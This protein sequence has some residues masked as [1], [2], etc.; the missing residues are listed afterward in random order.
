MQIN[1]TYNCSNSLDLRDRSPGTIKKKHSVSE[2]DLT[3]HR[4]N[5]LFLGSQKFE[6]NN[7]YSYSTVRNI[8]SF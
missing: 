4:S 8:T 1:L 7:D 5:K 2:I 6:Q 3:F